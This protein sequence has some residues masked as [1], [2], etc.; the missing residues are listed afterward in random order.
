MDTLTK[1]LMA[2]S[3][4]LVSC[5][6]EPS[7]KTEPDPEPIVPGVTDTGSL[8]PENITLVARVTGRTQSGENI[9]N[10]NN[11]DARFGI[12][13]TDYGNMW[14]AGNGKVMCVFGDNF[15]HSG[16]NWKSNAIAITTDRDLSD[17][18]YYDDM[19]KDGSG[20]KEI[21]VSRAKTGQNADG[22]EYE[23]TC[24]PTAGIAVGNRQY[25]NYMSIHD[26]KPT[27]DNDQWSV[28]YSEIVYSDDYGSTWK[29][30]GV[31]WGADSKF[32][33]IAYLK[34]KGSVYVYGTQAG[35]YGS[36][37]LARV[38]E[39]KML[40]KSAYEYWT[41]GAWSRDEAAAV[42]VA[43]GT[44]SE[45]TVAYNS[46]YDRYM[47]MYLSV[48]QRAIV[49]RDAPSPTGEWSGE[50]I[51]M[52]EDGNA[53]YAP[54][55]HPWFNDKEELWFVLSHAVPT[56]NVF[57]MRADLKWDAAGVNLVA[58]GGFE[59]Y[60]NQA[61]GYK[62]MW[63]VNAD[64]LTSRQAHT[65]KVACRFSNTVSGQWQDVC[66]QSVAVKH[67]T[68][69]TIECWVKSDEQLPEGAYVGVRL[70]D[71]TIC[72][73]TGTADAGEWT[74]LSCDFNSGAAS[75]VEVFFGVWG[76]PA[77]TLTVDDICLKP[78][79]K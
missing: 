66:T 14:D 55:I 23:V 67:S 54:Y 65:G 22:S 69:Y 1:L 64:A 20:V 73:A 7:G 49:Y 36:V 12:G 10:P 68:D 28:N 40:E 4:L 56:W 8:L 21:I 62:T 19:L 76:G 13:R 46:R 52:Y 63:N 48:N 31:K 58:E 30:S 2:A 42:P 44:A 38:D 51:I 74:R 33:Q 70:P 5:H 3:V 61:L 47:M 17:G 29:R 57:L 72:D 27:G 6:S 75:D 43:K 37:Y 11:T 34:E 18:L 24:I 45:M 59:E 35:R 50:K 60:P 15:S 39:N 41:G 16:G 32:A 9:P 79:N 26:W 77:M 71:G 25:L 53:L 78:K